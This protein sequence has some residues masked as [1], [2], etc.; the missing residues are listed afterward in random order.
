MKKGNKII[1]VIA[2][3]MVVTALLMGA[4]D[5]S[6]IPE[7]FT[8]DAVNPLDGKSLITENLESRAVERHY[9]ESGYSFVETFINF[10]YEGEYYYV[11][12]ER[13]VYKTDNGSLEIHNLNDDIFIG[14]FSKFKFEETD[15]IF[16]ANSRNIGIYLNENYLYYYMYKYIEYKDYWGGCSPDYGIVL[17]KNYQAVRFDLEKGENEEI[18]DEEFFEAIK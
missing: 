7:G 10:D 15:D 16:G 18:T 8:K 4:V 6:K 17:Y 9:E 2:L 14:K 11:W 3:I 13:N 5:K 1:A 12:N